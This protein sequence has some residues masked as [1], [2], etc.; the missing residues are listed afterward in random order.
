MKPDLS[1]AQLR[2]LGVTPDLLDD[3][4]EGHQELVETYVESGLRFGLDATEEVGGRVLGV[5]VAENIVG[6][7][8]TGQAALLMLVD[9]LANSDAGL[10]SRS[11]RGV[12]IIYEEVGEIRANAGFQAKYRPV[13]GGVSI[14][15]C[16]RAYSG[17]LGCVVSSNGVKYILSNNHVLADVNSLAAGATISQQSTQDGGACPADVI[18]TLSQFVPIVIGGV[19]TVD[20]AIAAISAG[21]NV[22]AR[23][24]R[25]NG[26]VEKLVA[27]VT[28]PVLNLAVQKSGRTTGYTRAATIKAIGVTLTVNMGAAGLST[29]NNVFTSQR[30][31]GLFSDAG[32][33]GS[34]ITTDPSNQPV[35]LLF[36]GDSAQKLTYANRMSDVLTALAAL[37]GAAVSVV[38]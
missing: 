31:S 10:P 14:A 37:T 11:S 3:L 21:V 8:P 19:S 35:G 13:Q 28:A 32:D 4:L 25:D 29:F 26:A 33:S 17:T 2:D 9:N 7:R 27:P 23:I 36:A 20:A 22:D 5:G 18:A 6:G 34:L 12:P 15:P 16:A 38:Y 1:L 24:M 30:V